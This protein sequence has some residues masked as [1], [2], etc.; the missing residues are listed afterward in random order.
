MSLGY[1]HSLATETRL[2]VSVQ[3]AQFSGD[4]GIEDNPH[5]SALTDTAASHVRNHLT[6]CPS[7]KSLKERALLWRCRLLRVNY[8]VAF[9]V[10]LTPSGTSTARRLASAALF[11]LKD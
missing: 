6:P 9:D 3:I 5:A 7:P 8:H 10:H 1:W 2:R 11:S 4:W